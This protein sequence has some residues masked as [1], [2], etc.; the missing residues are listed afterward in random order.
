[1]AWAKC[2]P[3]ETIRRK[4]SGAP[5]ASGTALLAFFTERSWR[6]MRDVQTLSLL[7]SLT[8]RSQMP[9]ES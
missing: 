4:R 5:A 2:R 7:S 8:R 3:S 6:V 9:A 1:M